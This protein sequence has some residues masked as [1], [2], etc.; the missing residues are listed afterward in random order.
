MDK[1]SK[2]IRGACAAL[3]IGLGIKNI[4]LD[5]SIE[6]GLIQIG[7]GISLLFLPQ[8]ITF[9]G[10]FPGVGLNLYRALTIPLFWLLNS[11]GFSMYKL[12]SGR[13][14]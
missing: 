8:T 11:F 1:R 10:L 5:N 14:S 4:V 9:L 3:N 13:K 6:I 7:I 12:F 2:I